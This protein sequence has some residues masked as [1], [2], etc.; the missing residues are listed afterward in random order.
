M[1]LRGI[2]C[3][4]LLQIYIALRASKTSVKVTIV[5]SDLMHMSPPSIDLVQHLRSR[6]TFRENV[7]T[8]VFI[9]EAG[10]A[11]LH[12][13]TPATVTRKKPF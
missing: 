1:S 2:K 7:H 5:D 6:L 9:R 11:D 8:I 4:F 12:M 13:K 3:Y 10:L